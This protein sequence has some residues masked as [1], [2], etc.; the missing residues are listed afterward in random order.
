M[1]KEEVIQLLD[2]CLN[3]SVFLQNGIVYQQKE[4]IPMGSPISVVLAELTMQHIE[5]IIMSLAPVKPKIWKR[6]LDDTITILPKTCVDNFLN[7]I[8]SHIQFTYELEVNK[9]IPFLDLLVHRKEAGSLK[10]SIFR[11]PTFTGS[12]LKF[13]SY[14]SMSQKRAVVK[15]LIDRARNLCDEDTLDN[16][17]NKITNLLKNNGY[18]ISFTNSIINRVPRNVVHM[19]DA[20]RTKYIS[21]PYIK[22]TSE[23]VGRTL[24]EHNIKL[25]NKSSNTFQNKL[26]NMKD[27]RKIMENDNVIYEIP[28]SDCNVSYVGE[29]KKQLQ[30]RVKQHKAA[31]RN[32][33]QLSLIFQHVS[34][35]NHTMNFEASKVLSKCMY[36]KPRRLIESF[37]TYVKPA[38]INRSRE[39]S[40]IYKPIIHKLIGNN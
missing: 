31:V 23:R 30:D 17:L 37:Y 4:G 36:E 7:Q 19:N 40:E 5:S 16:E 6:Y 13:D 33:T 15:S 32:S 9:E 35:H 8:N 12:Y 38:A 22:G 11:K 39:F 21:A 34:E 14:H 20:S 18:P 29:T 24:R 1:S 27:K 25:S 28:C 10:F 26:C 2:I 3:A